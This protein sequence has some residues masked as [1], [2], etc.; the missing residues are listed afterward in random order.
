MAPAAGRRA[1]EA[2]QRHLAVL[3]LAEV[4]GEAGAGL[5]VARRL[6]VHELADFRRDEVRVGA[7]RVVAL[8]APRLVRRPR[9][10]LAEEL[11]RLGARL[12]AQHLALE[13]RGDG[14]DLQP[15]FLRQVDALRGVGGG[16][17]VGVALAQVQLP[18]C[19]LPAVEA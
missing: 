3:Q 15:V 18:A 8:V 16:A 2:R 6:L 1:D 11:Q 12:V 10:A 5:Q 9:L 13:V 19:L 7:R 4:A 14:K 17:A